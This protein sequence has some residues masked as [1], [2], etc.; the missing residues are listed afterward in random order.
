MAHSIDRH[1]VEIDLL[2]VRPR[3]EQRADPLH[4]RGQ[5]RHIARGLAAHSVQQ[6]RTAKLSELVRDLAEIKAHRQ[7]PNVMERFGPDP[8]EADERHGSPIAVATRADDHFKAA[9]GHGLDENAIDGE[10]GVQRSDLL[11]LRPGVRELRVVAD[12]EQHSAGV[13]LVR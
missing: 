9:R 13:A 5:R 2:N 6:R 12:V 7:Y 1:R 4:D 3:R 8:A 10:A 11:Q